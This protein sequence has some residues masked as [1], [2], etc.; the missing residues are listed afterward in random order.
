MEKSFLLRKTKRDLILNIS[1][2]SLNSKDKIQILRNIKNIKNQLIGK[3]DISKYNNLIQL[4]KGNKNEIDKKKFQEYS[5]I[6]GIKSITSLNE[7]NLYQ[8]TYLSNKK[9][10]IYLLKKPKLIITIYG[11]NNIKAYICFTVKQMEEIFN[12][13]K[14]YEF[15]RYEL[16]EKNM[17]DLDE[18]IPNDNSEEI[19]YIL[20]NKVNQQLYDLEKINI[21]ENYNKK[22]KKEK[23]LSLN[24][25]Y[26]YYFNIP[27]FLQNDYKYIKTT[28]RND[29][30]EFLKSFKISLDNSIYITG[31]KGMGKTASLIY[32][33]GENYNYIY[34]VNFK[35]ILNQNLDSTKIVL[36]YETLKFFRLNN[37]DQSS[38]PFID[39][40][41]YFFKGKNN[42]NNS[43]I[44]D[45]K[46]NDNTS[47]NNRNIINYKIN[48]SNLNDNNNNLQ[49]NEDDPILSII[50]LI[51]DL[52]PKKIYDFIINYLKCSLKYFIKNNIEAKLF[53]I[54]DQVSDNIPN[55]NIKELIKDIE[56]L[57]NIKIIVCSSLD[58]DFSKEG[59][60]NI[61]DFPTKLDKIKFHYF[62]GFLNSKNDIELFLEE[63]K[64]TKVKSEFMKYNGNPMIYYLLKQNDEEEFKLLK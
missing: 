8:I 2:D 25:A 10:E 41:K 50:Q 53:I 17:I 56:K 59:L 18:N 24:K 6:N 39:E 45:D 52:D 36:L 64:E 63:E 32:F 61:F 29:F 42:D 22:L 55:L 9:Y 58:N 38:K 30:I 47:Y 37:K 62:S 7:K 28:K 31:P 60:Y 16:N 15:N 23:A 3:D 44:I 11:I 21:F 14:K 40:I 19:L 27:P 46:N 48:D 20:N 33:C 1:K 4:L 43:N 49:K 26:F 57:K 12:E 51:R 13:I 54:M 34:Y 35:C 5:G